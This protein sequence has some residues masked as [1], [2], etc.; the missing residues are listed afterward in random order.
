[1]LLADDGLGSPTDLTVVGGSSD[2]GSGGPDSRCAGVSGSWSCN[3]WLR[4]SLMVG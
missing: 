1:M 4:L 3:R 2:L